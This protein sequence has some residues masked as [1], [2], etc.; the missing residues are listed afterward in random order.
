MKRLEPA[1]R[2]LREKESSRKRRARDRTLNLRPDEVLM[3]KLP[4]VQPATPEEKGT[5]SPSGAAAADRPGSRLTVIREEE[6]KRIPTGRGAGES[7]EQPGR[8]PVIIPAP[9]HR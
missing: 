3:R 2:G 6:G 5:F 9:P 8:G 4:V 7:G 1:R